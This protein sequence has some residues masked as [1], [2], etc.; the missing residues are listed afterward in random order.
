MKGGHKGEEARNIC[1][2]EH[3]NRKTSDKNKIKR[4]LLK[5]SVL[6]SGLLTFASC[7][8]L[9]A[10]STASD[11]NAK[12]QKIEMVGKLIEKD[13]GKAMALAEELLAVKDIFTGVVVDVLS[14]AA[15]KNPDIIMPLLVKLLTDENKDMRKYAVDVIFAATRSR[16]YDDKEMVDLKKYPEVIKEFGTLLTDKESEGSVEGGILHMLRECSDEIDLTGYQS[17]MK[18]LE[19]MLNDKNENSVSDAIWIILDTLEKA[20]NPDLSGY[21]ESVEGVG[22]LLTHQSYKYPAVRVLEL[23]AENTD[24]TTYPTIMEEL[25]KIAKDTSYRN[26]SLQGN[27]P[28]AHKTLASTLLKNTAKAIPY[29]EQLL[30][31]DAALITKSYAVQALGTAAANNPQETV[32]YLEK[33]LKNTYTINGA[34]SA[35]K[36]AAEENPQAM[37]PHILKLLNSEDKGMRWWVVGVV[38]ANNEEYFESSAMMKKIT[39]LL[40]NDEWE[41]KWGAAWAFENAARNGKNLSDYPGVMKNL[42]KLLDDSHWEMRWGASGALKATASNVNLSKY[43]GAIKKFGELL[44]DESAG[45][46]TNAAG[47]LAKT[48][49]YTDLSKYPGIV[50]KLG[51]LLKDTTSTVEQSDGKVVEIEEV[52]WN[53]C[54][55]LE[56][57]AKKNP[58]VKPQIKQLIKKSGINQ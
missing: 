36:C 32:P 1:G 6:L 44:E 11:I 41:V 17:V 25:V 55:A 31:E 33:W 56:A 23:I 2:K 3:N 26:W 9:P 22:K 8:P 50:K 4:V 5:C 14:D 30:A 45:V 28:E 53:A 24:L 43:D 12:Q 13:P 7:A 42:L 27:G 54:D 15:R 38:V 18:G 52:R 37:E 47:A 39:E 29:F 10:P 34:A 20:D 48:A 46:R 49:K 21:P 51:K 19:K 35:L 58:A 40:E 57:I 16:Y